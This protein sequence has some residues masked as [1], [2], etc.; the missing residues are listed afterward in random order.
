MLNEERTKILVTCPVC[1]YQEEV[2]DFNKD[3]EIC[4]H[5]GKSTYTFRTVNSIRK[6]FVGEL[7]KKERGEE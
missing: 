1:G 5:C 4:T 3:N 2:D 6:V 7:K